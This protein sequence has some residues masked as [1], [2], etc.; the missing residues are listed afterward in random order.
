MLREPTG[1]SL[2]H[3][4]AA[5]AGKRSEQAGTT[6][7]IRIVSITEGILKQLNGAVAVEVVVTLNLAHRMQVMNVAV[8]TLVAVIG[9]STTGTL[10][11]AVSK[12]SR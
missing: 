2:N 3:R 9:N 6:I 11:D 1:P 8:M 4:L 10:M 12:D 7:S 5:Q